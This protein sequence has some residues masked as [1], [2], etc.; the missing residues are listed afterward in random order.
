[1][2]Q[3]KPEW[4]VK[5]TGPCSCESLNIKL[6]CA[7][8]QSVTTIDSKVLSKTGDECLLNDGEPIDHGD[9]VFKYVW[10]TSFDFEIT[11]AKITCS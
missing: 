8:F 5:V 6:S 11:D 7:G 2:V 1:M 3:G 9:Y 10:D 4:E